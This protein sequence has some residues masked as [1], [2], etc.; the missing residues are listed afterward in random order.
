MIQIHVHVSNMCN[1]YM[2][3]SSLHCIFS[4]LAKDCYH[5]EDAVIHPLT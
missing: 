2:V 5:H 4:D 3:E 1:C